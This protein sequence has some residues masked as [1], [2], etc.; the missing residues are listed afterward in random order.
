[1]NTHFTHTELVYN[2]SA[3][4][5]IVPVILKLVDPE[6]VLDVGC[7]IGTWLKI[8]EDHH[9]NDY[10]GVDGDYVD[11]NLLKIPAERFYPC[12]LSKH[13]D[14]GRKFDLVISLEVAEHIA[15]SSADQFVASLVKHG[16]VL[17]FSAAIPWQGGQHHL[18]EQ[19][20]EYW[21]EKFKKFGFYFH[22]VIRP[23]I[24]NN[25]RVDFWYKQNMFLIKKERPERQPFRSLS[26][27]HP[28][29]F[30]LKMQNEKEFFQSLLE[31][32]H[33]LRMGCII[34]MNAI[35]FKIRSVF[36]SK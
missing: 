14:L 22:D 9:V 27:V 24:W 13:F 20:P 2:F 30:E 19:W 35:K 34:F 26:M 31:G 8:F 23:E 18:N 5:E 3:A 28:E 1:M 29:L 10:M 17:L 25:V 16:D 32:R 33:G 11:R 7:G 4:R 21:E 6:S 15:E 36:K 12:D